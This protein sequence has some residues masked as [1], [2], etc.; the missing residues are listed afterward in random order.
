MILSFAPSELNKDL[1]KALIRITELQTYISKHEEIQG[2]SPSLEI[3]Y[4]WTQKL[5]MLYDYL[6]PYYL[7]GIAANAVLENVVLKLRRIIK[8]TDPYAL[9]RERK[10]IC[11][12]ENLIPLPLKQYEMVPLDPDPS[13]PLVVGRFKKALN[14][15]KFLV[16]AISQNGQRLT[17]QVVIDTLGDFTEYGILNDGAFELNYQVNEI[18]SGGEDYME[19]VIQGHNLKETAYINVFS[20]T[21]FTTNT[22]QAFKPDEGFDYQLPLIF[23]L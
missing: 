17:S 20:Y 16:T 23:V 12:P 3:E 6:V 2:V 11:R 9:R 19:L 5:S 13:N 22:K 1:V 15:G 14:I 10:D 7:T 18:A 21:Q 4:I 8:T